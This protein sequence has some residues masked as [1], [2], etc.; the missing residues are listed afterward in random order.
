MRILLFSFLIVLSA[1]LSAQN[2]K[3]N[4]LLAYIKAIPPEM[5]MGELKYT[6]DGFGDEKAFVEPGLML[7]TVLSDTK[8]ESFYSDVKE[9][10]TV[11][12]D[13]A[14][15]RFESLQDTLYGSVNK[16][17]ML[18][19]KS[20][21]DENPTTDYFFAHYTPE[22]APVE[23]SSTSWKGNG[24]SG[25]F[26]N[27]TFEFRAN[28]QLFIWDNGKREEREFYVHELGNYWAIEFSSEILT[29]GFGMIY[30][31]KG[32][33]KTLS[34]VAYLSL[35]EDKLPVRSQVSFTKL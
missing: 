20:T 32:S 21:I 25:F 7:L 13:G 3:G 8:A 10:W 5:E 22:A 33:S 1:S 31:E 9:S 34:G 16:E 14:K 26:Q 30:I 28:D 17:G 27:K 4:W 23:L 2:L 15:V 24:N 18:V 29:S 12:N 6:E 11:I 19:L 35:E